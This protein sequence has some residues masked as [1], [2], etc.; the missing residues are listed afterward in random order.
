MKPQTF[1]TFSHLD[2]YKQFEGQVDKDIHD[3]GVMVK[4]APDLLLILI[5]TPK[6]MKTFNQIPTGLG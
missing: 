4:I 2:F 6:K 5:I 3:Q 1:S